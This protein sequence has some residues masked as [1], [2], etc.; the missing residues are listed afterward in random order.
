VSRRWQVDDRCLLFFV[1]NPASGTVK[2]RLAQVLGKEI[3]ADLYKSFVL[4]M[5]TALEKKDFPLSICFYPGDALADI[6]RVLGD[7]YRYQPQQGVDLGGR[8]VHCLS[9]VFA[10][11][12]N[13]AVLIGSD[14]PDVPIAII[15]EAFA[16]LQRVDTVIGPALDGGYYLIGFAKDNFTPEVFKG[17]PWGTET[18]LQ[19]TI[20]KLKNLRRTIHLLPP[21]EDI[22]TLKDLKNFYDRNR[23]TRRCARTMTYLKAKNVLP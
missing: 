14:V 13:R 7:H 17:L 9:T 19:Q 2:S 16:S 20:D 4:D 8:M 3:A 1:R 18:I 6:K 5:L 23:E 21:W 10:A 11:G 15:N 22:D 12:V